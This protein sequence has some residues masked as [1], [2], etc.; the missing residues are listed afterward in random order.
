M[1]SDFT[2][3]GKLNVNPN[4]LV[5]ISFSSWELEIKKKKESLEEKNV[6][7]KSTPATFLC[8]E[9]LRILAEKK[10]I[11]L[12]AHLHLRETKTWSFEE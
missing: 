1:N 12:K 7:L 2:L 4:F 11:K 5:L 10:E 3:E 8:E 6:L 9:I